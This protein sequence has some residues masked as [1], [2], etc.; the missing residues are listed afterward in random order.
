MSRQKSF[1][2]QEQNDCCIVL[3][4][5]NSRKK[6]LPLH[7]NETVDFMK[8]T[9]K[10]SVVGWKKIRRSSGIFIQDN[11]LHLLFS[12]TSTDINKNAQEE[13]KHTR[14]VPEHEAS[15]KVRLF[16]SLNKEKWG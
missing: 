16:P 11:H 9:W 7:K 6:R 5:W 13:E 3:C 10:I 15:R 4:E 12:Q 14:I 2:T 8:N 1:V